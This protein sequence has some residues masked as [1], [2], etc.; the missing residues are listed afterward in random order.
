M[1]TTDAIALRIA[2]SA[3]TF[4]RPVC[5]RIA[6]VD[7]AHRNAQ[8]SALS[9]PIAATR[10]QNLLVSAFALVCCCMAT[11]AVVPYRLTSSRVLAYHVVATCVAAIIPRPAGR[12]THF[13]AELARV[14][15]V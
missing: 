6:M 5:E 15:G 3:S 11:D 14:I 7:D 8:A 4:T 2:F 9:S 13:I 1:N 10:P 12:P